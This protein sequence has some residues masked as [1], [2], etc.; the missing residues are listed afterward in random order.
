MLRMDFLMNVETWSL[1]LMAALIGIFVVMMA[2]EAVGLLRVAE[3]EQQ[4]RYLTVSA[5]VLGFGVWSAY[6]L[7]T[8]AIQHPADI[9]FD[10]P[11]VLINIFPAMVFGG[12]ALYLVTLPTPKAVRVGGSIFAILSGITVIHLSM[13]KTM[14]TIPSN[15]TVSSAG[16]DPTILGYLVALAAFF[17]LILAFNS[18]YMKRK[19]MVQS[20]EADTK[21]Q[22]LIESAHDA[23]IVTDEQNIIVQWNSGAERLFGHEREWIIGQPIF[24]VVPPQIHATYQTAVSTFLSLKDHSNF[25]R[26]I[27][28]L[29]LDKKQRE[30]PIEVSIGTWTIGDGRYISYIV[31]DITDRKQEEAQMKDLVYLDDLTG[32][33]NRRLFTERIHSML[34]RAKE[35]DVK[36]AVIYLDID[37]FKTVNDRFGHPVGDDLLIQVTKR[38]YRNMGM[39]D[40]IARIG[41]DEF[42]FLLTDT[43]EEKTEAF[44]KGLVDAFKE[45]FRLQ[46]EAIHISPSIGISMYPS[47]GKDANTLIRNSDAA[48]YRVKNSGKNGY[49]FYRDRQIR[50]VGA[51]RNSL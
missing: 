47:D 30:F 31:R 51:M 28:T 22:A 29:A 34:V 12:I 6:F 10:L 20:S 11:V 8:L 17:L 16:I 7:G 49:Q 23:I 48:L 46:G 36:F 40:T 26:M 19:M 5:I 32:L 43:T 44:A 13:M 41:G 39:Y 21:F 24:T 1:L 3:S 37:N 18:V 50:E 38:I 45:P 33:P 9:E 42:S 2:L 14:V 4:K 35:R 15:S 25:T 27:E